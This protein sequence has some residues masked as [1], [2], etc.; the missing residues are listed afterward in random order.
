M[1]GDS[2]KPQ[3]GV[4]VR[5]RGRPFYWGFISIFGYAFLKKRQFYWGFISIFGYAFLKKRVHSSFYTGDTM[6]VA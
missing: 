3:R 2:R 5:K 1:F 4:L 6:L